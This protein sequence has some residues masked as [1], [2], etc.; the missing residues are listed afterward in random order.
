M[1]IDKRFECPDCGQ[2]VLNLWN[3]GCKLS[4]A[5][6][7]PLTHPV[8]KPTIKERLNAQAQAQDEVSVHRTPVTV[9]RIEPNLPKRREP[10]SGSERVK[11]WRK[12]HPEDAKRVHREYMRTW[13]GRR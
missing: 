12:A 10:L 6:K 3:H 9:K 8:P 1:A 5:E 4:K 11:K 7:P 13:R 2:T